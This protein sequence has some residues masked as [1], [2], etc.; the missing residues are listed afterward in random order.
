MT[1]TPNAMLPAIPGLNARMVVRTRQVVPNDKTTAAAPST[2]E[3]DID[4]A[5]IR[6]RLGV[7]QARLHAC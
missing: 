4:G 3:I 5:I 2:I 7:D 1:P 6:V